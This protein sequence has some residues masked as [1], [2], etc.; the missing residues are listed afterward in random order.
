MR[1]ADLKLLASRDEESQALEAS[2][3]TSHR[4]LSL[5]RYGTERQRDDIQ[6]QVGVCRLDELHPHP[7]DVRHHLAV[8]ASQLSALVE[9]GDLAFREPTVITQDR[10]IVDGYARVELARMQGRLTLPCIE[11]QLTEAE[12]LHWLLQR[13]RRSNGLNAFSR[14]LL[15]LEL[16]AGFKEKARANQ[17]AGGQNKGSSSLT[18]AERLDVRSEIAAAAGVSVG[19]VSKVKQLTIAH[20]K[21][22]EALR[23][24]EISINK[25]SQWSTESPEEQLELLERDQ[26]QRGTKKTIRILISR[27]K[28]KRPPTAPDIG[29]LISRLCSLDLSKLGPVSVVVMKAPGKAIFLSEPLF[30]ALESQGELALACA[31]NSR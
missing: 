11:Y 18:E 25:A 4:P 28:S 14:I 29:E 12:A 3:S 31:T 26:S 2:I 7:G 22:L 8:P 30:R 13:H 6:G 20:P 21:P 15:A 5:G 9:L 19:N 27:H 23:C 10:T 17:R 1:R 16:E 24:G